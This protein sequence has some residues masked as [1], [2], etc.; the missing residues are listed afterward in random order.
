MAKIFRTN[1]LCFVY[2]LTGYTFNTRASPINRAK[3]KVPRL[4][5]M[6]RQVAYFITVW[7]SGQLCHTIYHVA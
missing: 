3:P 6:G 2:C 5:M 1:R 7:Y 4:L